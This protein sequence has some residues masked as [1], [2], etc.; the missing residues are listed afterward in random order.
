MG[1]PLVNTYYN[2]IQ[3]HYILLSLSIILLSVLLRQNTYK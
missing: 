3:Y 2:F 1:D